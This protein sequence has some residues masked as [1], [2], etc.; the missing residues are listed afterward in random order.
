MSGDDA[1]AVAT[2]RKSLFQQTGLKNLQYCRQIHGN[3]VIDV[4]NTP[5]VSVEDPPEADA[6]VSARRRCGVGY[7]TADCVPIFIYDAVTPA[8]GIAHARMARHLRTRRCERAR[9]NGS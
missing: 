8:I 3:C 5:R 2:N 4:D 6:L 9:A 1:K 7:F